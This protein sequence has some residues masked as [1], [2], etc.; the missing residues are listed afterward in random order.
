MVPV[1]AAIEE[2]ARAKGAVD[3]GIAFSV[4]AIS[5]R[6]ILN[7]TYAAAQIRRVIAATAVMLRNANRGTIA[8]LHTDFELLCRVK[9]YFDKL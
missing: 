7:E 4:K 2:A 1:Y 8:L 9:F 6:K 5:F 3:F